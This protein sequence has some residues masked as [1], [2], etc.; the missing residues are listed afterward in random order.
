MIIGSKLRFLKKHYNNNSF[1]LFQD[2][3]ITNLFINCPTGLQRRLG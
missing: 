3:K 2:E 1:K